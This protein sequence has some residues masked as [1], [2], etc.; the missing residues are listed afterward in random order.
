[1]KITRENKVKYKILHLLWEVDSISLIDSKRKSKQ[2]SW[3][4]RDN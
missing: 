4:K 3:R 2:V 1:V